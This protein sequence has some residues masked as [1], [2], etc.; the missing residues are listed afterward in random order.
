MHSVK[1]PGQRLMARDFDRHVAE[2]QVRIAVINGL[3]ASGILVTDSRGMNPSGEW[4]AP[5]ITRFVQ[6]SPSI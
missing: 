5:G 1:R 3:T 2:V 6:Q 4:G